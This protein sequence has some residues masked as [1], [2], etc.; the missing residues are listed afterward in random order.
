L[1]DFLAIQELHI[2]TIEEG[3]AT[4]EANDLVGHEKALA[5]L[6]KMM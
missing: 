3:I 6:K 5:E 1:E 4:V 2:N